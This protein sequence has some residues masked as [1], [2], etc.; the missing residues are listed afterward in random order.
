MPVQSC[1][2][3]LLPYPPGIVIHKA[4]H[5]PRFH[6]TRCLLDK[7]LDGLLWTFMDHKVIDDHVQA[8]LLEACGL[9]ETLYELDVAARGR[10]VSPAGHVTIRH[11]ECHQKQWAAQSLAHK[12]RQT[13]EHTIT[14]H[15]NRMTVV[16]NDGKGQ[17]LERH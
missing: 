1:A 4:Q 11:Q 12:S 6:N 3:I 14:I 17:T 7:V 5:T 10:R 9:A 2:V 15:R 8:A 13:A 16:C